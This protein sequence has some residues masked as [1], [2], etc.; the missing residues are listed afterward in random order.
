[1]RYISKACLPYPVQGRIIHEA[2]GVIQEEEPSRLSSSSPTFRGDVETI[3]AKA[4]EKD[5]DRRYQSAAELA[6]DIRRYL[7]DERHAFD[8]TVFAVERS[9]YLRRQRESDDAQV[10]VSR[11]HSI[12]LGYG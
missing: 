10:P 1:M 5:K 11:G 6:A 2:V 3:I 4:L 8:R 12:E 7:T 9:G